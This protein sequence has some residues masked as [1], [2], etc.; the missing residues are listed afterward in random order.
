[1]VTNVSNYTEIVI[2]TKIEAMFFL[3]RYMYDKGTLLYQSEVSDLQN[4]STYTHT[5]H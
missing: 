3:A 5:K 1:M 4:M 2:L